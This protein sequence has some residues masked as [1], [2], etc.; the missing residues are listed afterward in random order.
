MQHVAHEVKDVHEEIEEKQ[1][2]HGVKQWKPGLGV[3]HPRRMVRSQFNAGA[4]HQTSVVKRKEKR[5][6]NRT[7]IGTRTSSLL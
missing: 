1:A 7:T 6:R 4:S 2:M 5:N 3:R